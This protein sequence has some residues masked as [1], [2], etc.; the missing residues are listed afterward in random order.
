MSRCTRPLVVALT[1]SLLVAARHNSGMYLSGCR[2]HDSSYSPTRSIS[3]RTLS[4]TSR[5]LSRLH[6]A[7]MLS[8]LLILCFA[9]S[10]CF[11]SASAR[12]TLTP[13]PNNAST[14]SRPQSLNAIWSQGPG[15][16]WFTGAYPIGN[17][18]LGE[19][20]LGRPAEDVHFVSISPTNIEN[21]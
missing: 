20:V 21:G 5:I 12:I 16:D 13:P 10:G 7:R 3:T 17:G 9:F 4:A 8:K 2:S 14:S 6:L 11:S 19:M 18:Y 1:M 15:T